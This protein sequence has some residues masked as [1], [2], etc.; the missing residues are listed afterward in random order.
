MLCYCH[1]RGQQHER[2]S[3]IIVWNNYYLRLSYFAIIDQLIR[4]NDRDN[5]LETVFRSDL[6]LNDLIFI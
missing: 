5:F 1:S 2:H 6:I 4:T 3:I